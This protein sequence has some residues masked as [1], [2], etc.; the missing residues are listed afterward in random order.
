MGGNI[1]KPGSTKIIPLI[2]RNFPFWNCIFGTDILFSYV[3]LENGFLKLLL[4]LIQMDTNHKLK[5][6]SESDMYHGN[7]RDYYHRDQDPHYHDPRPQ[8][9][10]KEPVPI[11]TCP[12]CQKNVMTKPKKTLVANQK[13]LGWLSCFLDPLHWCCCLCCFITPCVFRKEERNDVV[14]YC[15]S[16][17]MLIEIDKYEFK[18]EE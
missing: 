1:L 6:F 8:I 3:L 9:G 10:A 12:H 7:N 15:P 2:W 16:C 5:F 14:H 17:K 11:L 4:R 18:K 13:F